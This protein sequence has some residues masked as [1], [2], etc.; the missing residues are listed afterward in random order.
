[1]ITQLAEWMAPAMPLFM[2]VAV[3]GS[4]ALGWVAARITARVLVE[5]VRRTSRSVRA[6]TEQ[7]EDA[8]YDLTAERRL[9]DHLAEDLSETRRC[10]RSVIADP[11]KASPRHIAMD[12]VREVAARP[13]PGESTGAHAAITEETDRG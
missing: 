4:V 2:L 12:R 13:L 8:E 9:V 5:K 1:M 3:A 7:I 11:L 10:L 6:L